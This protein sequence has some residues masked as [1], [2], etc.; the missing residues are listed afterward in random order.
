LLTIPQEHPQILTPPLEETHMNNLRP[1]NR[2]AAVG[3]SLLAA[4]TTAGLSVTAAAV[5]I[6]AD[7]ADLEE[8]IAGTGPLYVSQLMGLADVVGAAPLTLLPAG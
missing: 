6:G 4:L 1:P 2:T 8:A 7:P 3:A 5:A